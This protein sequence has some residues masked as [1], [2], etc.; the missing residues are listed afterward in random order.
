[1]QSKS[2]RVAFLFV[3]LSSVPL[4]AAKFWQSKDFTSWTEKEC[5]ELLRKS[6]WAQ[7]NGFGSVP[8]IGAM[9]ADV[10]A[11]TVGAPTQ[12]RFGEQQSTIMFE[13][14]ALTAK[15]IKLALA[16]LQMIQRPG[17]A[18]LKELANR[19]GKEPPGDEIIVQIS[20]RTIP[21]GSSVIH[22]INSYFLHSTGVEF[23][24]STSL[25]SEGSGI[26][27]LAK[28]L[29]PNAGQI[30]PLFVFPRLNEKGA[31]NFT[32]NEKS[33]ALQSEFTPE[34]SGVQQRY[35]IFIRF[36]PK[37]MKFQNEFTF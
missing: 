19:M 9:P 4:F 10:P 21:P 6:P 36:N 22:D 32:G 17:D 33:I 28:Y 5:M 2:L 26:V 23:R 25:A 27:P 3:L 12:P 14:R 1:M 35:S 8:A 37:D 30:N 18:A 31:P 24:H 11:P 13:F 16:R 7:S 15:P 29:P 20:Y 34:L